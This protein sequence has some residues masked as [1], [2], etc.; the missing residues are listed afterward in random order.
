MA[1][2]T[3]SPQSIPQDFIP[4]LEAEL[5]VVPDKTF[6]YARWLR[7]A[8]LQ[9]EMREAFPGEMDVIAA[10]VRQGAPVDKGAVAN[11]IEAM[12]AGMGG[13]LD[14]SGGLV[15]PDMVKFAAEAKN[16]GEIILI[17]RPKFL[18]SSTTLASRKFRAGDRM[19]GGTTQALQ[20]DQVAITI[21]IN[22]GP[23]DGSGNKAPISIFLF[24]QMR[25]FHDLLTMAR[26]A[27]VRDRNKFLDD[28]V[29]TMLIAAAAAPTSNDG[30]GIIR[31][32]DELSANTGF[33]GATNEPFTF[34]IM[35]KIAERFAQR[36]IPGLNGER[37]YVLVLD[38][39]QKQQLENDG[40]WQRLVRYYP[41]K[42]PVFPG[43]VG[44]TNAFI[45]CES[46]NHPRLTTLGAG[47]NIT[48][49]QAIALAPEVFGWAL[50]MN[51]RIMR[52]K[53]DDGDNYARFGWQSFEGFSTLNADF[54]INAITD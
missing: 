3:T 45:L 8:Q 40:G 19:F 22:V 31:G 38:T 29:I 12:S 51:P 41:E 13:P 23:L 27:L 36:G 44:E 39:H 2:T 25:A 7:A 6:V 28:N 14:V 34:G 1:E 10:Q 53:N 24:A 50:A 15:F 20:M 43:Y 16:P 35:P 47:S 26:L 52:D 37:K 48:G 42:N 46:N 33:T 54:V 32:E 49:Y 9:S 30:K 4:R 21:D 18:N 11:M 5:L 17:N